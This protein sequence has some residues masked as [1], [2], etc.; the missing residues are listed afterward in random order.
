MILSNLW[1]GVVSTVTGLKTTLIASAAVGIIAFGSGWYLGSTHE[2][3]I[4]AN[5]ATQA[6]SVAQA[7]QAKKDQADWVKAKAD[8]DK[9]ANE[10]KTAENALDKLVKAGP[11]IVIKHVVDPSKPAPQEVPEVAANS[12]HLLNDPDLVGVVQ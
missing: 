12:M 2:S 3:K 8:A 9:R 10:A 6:A 1:S 11:T 4:M 5:A 7:A